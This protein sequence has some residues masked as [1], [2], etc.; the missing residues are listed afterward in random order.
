MK[1]MMRLPAMPLVVNDPYFSIWSAYD[2]LTDGDTTHWAGARK[3]LYGEVRVNGQPY[4][5]LGAGEAPAATQTDAVVM[6]TRS[7]FGFE[8][9]GAE[10]TVVFETPMLPEDMDLFSTPVTSVCFRVRR[11]E[12]DVEFVFRAYDD[13]CYD[14]DERPA[15]LSDEFDVDGLHF[16]Y[17]GRRRQNMLSHSGDHITIDWG[18]LYLASRESVRRGEDYLEMAFRA[19]EGKVTEKQLLLGYDDVASINYFGMPAKAWY[20]RNGAT[21]VDAMAKIDAD[22]TLHDRCAEFDRVINR[23]STDR[24]GADYVFITAAAYRHAIAAHKLIADENG[25]MVLLSKE[26]DSNGCIGTVDVSYPSI[27]LFLLLKPELV[28]AMCRPVLKFA[29]LPVWKYDF[30]PHDVGRYPHAIGQVYGARAERVGGV[31]NGDV[32]PPYYLYPASAEIYKF[33]EQMPVEECGNMLIMIAAAAFADGNYQF[34]AQHMNLLEKWVKYLIEF[35]E[36]P[37]EQLCTD[38]FAGHLARNVNLSAKAIVGV[39]CFARL[40]TGLGEHEQAVAY[41]QKAEDMAQSWLKRASTPE[42]HTALTFDGQ[43]WSMKYNLAWDKVMHLNLL[44]GDFYRQ[45]IASY[46]PR[47]NEYGLPLDSRRTYTK[48]DWLLWIAAMAEKKDFGAFIA[49]V[50]HMLKTTE[51]RVPFS[52]WYDTVSGRYESFIARSVQGGL[53]MP[54]LIQ[55]EKAE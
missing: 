54:L 20:A 53:F 15:M 32:H 17:T 43:G 12:G 24:G 51:S 13:I 33:E 19:D 6:A 10:F 37:G 50:V 11:A 35:G 14:G 41:D 3:R 18:Y 16:A 27:P 25:E 26:N 4:R 7:Y 55:P 36:D 1:N 40:L 45:E 9:P 42:G 5:F 52:D 49:P 44:P 22:E 46:L 23:V 30:A 38:D 48:S 2:N 31:E 29:N 21:L 28:R 8:A 47:I 34:A 39:K